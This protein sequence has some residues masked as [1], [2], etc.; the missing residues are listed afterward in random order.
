MLK[1]KVLAA[2]VASLG[3]AMP[4]A[5]AEEAASPHSVTGNLTFVSDYIVRGI[6][7]TE[8]KPAVQGTVE[9][10]HASG[11]YAGLFG[12]NVSWVSDF[13]GPKADG[14]G[15]FNGSTTA[16]SAFELDLYAGFRNKFLGDFSYD[17]GAVYYWYP[18]RYPTD[19]VGGAKSANTGE[20]YGALG[21]KWITAKIWYAV[22]DDVFLVPDASGTYYANLAANVP[23]GQT[24]F[25]AYAH[26]GTWKWAGGGAY[27]FDNS[28]Y[29]AVDWKIG[30]TKDLVGFTWGLFYSDTNGDPVYWSDRYGKNL[31][32]ETVFLQVTKAF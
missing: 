12:S 24:G 3:L 5:H 18:G 11:L 15:T 8:S 14:S 1:K 23:I 19:L 22:T 32:K 13:T 2:T 10:G 30:A 25:N 21:W 26:V 31:S 16:S 28:N 9:Y 17:V 27:G 20:I 29:D 7:Q 6:T 4:F